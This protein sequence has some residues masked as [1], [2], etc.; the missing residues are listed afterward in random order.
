MRCEG[1]DRHLAAGV[2]ASGPGQGTVRD[3]IAC[4]AGYRTGRN[5]FNPGIGNFARKGEEIE[6]VADA[7]GMKNGAGSIGITKHAAGDALPVLAETISIV[8]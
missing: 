8:T 4:F 6:P 3:E 5:R 7:G 1:L 2:G